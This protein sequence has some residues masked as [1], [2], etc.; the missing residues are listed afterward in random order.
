MRWIDVFRIAF[1]MLQTNLLRSILTVLGIGVAISL[2]VVLIGL[3]YGLQE[4]AIGSI[5]ESKELLSLDITA[6]PEKGVPVTAETA[7]EI[8]KLSGIKEVSPVINTGGEIRLK[9]KLA[10]VAVTAGQHNFLEMEGVKLTQGRAYNDN[11]NEVII[12]PQLLDLLDIKREDALNSTATINFN[13]PNNQN[14]SKKIEGATVVGI[15]ESADTPTIYIPFSLV[16]PSDPATK[17]SAIK[18][19]ATDRANVVST[20]EALIAKGYQVETL[21]ETLDQARTVFKWVTLGLTAFGM[22]ALIVASI[23]MFNTLTIA[24]LE[25]TREIGIMKAIGITDETVKRLFLAESA[26][27]GLGGGLTGI[28]IGLSI[29]NL[30]GLILDRIAVTYGGTPVILFKYPPGFLLAMLLFPIALATFTGLY[31]AIRASH[32]NPLRALKYE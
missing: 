9:E 31:P 15:T 6:L 18:A 11:A 8:Q 21:I 30:L 5:V 4:I 26:I 13:D 19:A 25:R 32:L 24:L 17:V 16:A 28:G 14:Q 20:S 23:G 3:G 1:R 7:I 2:I 10:A 29:D 12:S 22:I 27:L